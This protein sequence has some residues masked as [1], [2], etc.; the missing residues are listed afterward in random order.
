MCYKLI[1]K[2]NNNNV[3]KININKEISCSIQ[4]FSK[5]I[6]FINNIMMNSQC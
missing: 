4:R 2:I 3:Y 6:N 5:C 1:L